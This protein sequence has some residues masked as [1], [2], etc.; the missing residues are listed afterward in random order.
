MQFPL[1]LV[2]DFEKTA[3]KRIRYDAEVD[4]TYFMKQI[5]FVQS[6]RFTAV[7]KNL[8]FPVVQIRRRRQNEITVGI[9]EAVS[10]K[11]VILACLTQCLRRRLAKTAFVALGESTQMGKATVQCNGRD[12]VVL[13]WREQSPA[14]SL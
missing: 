13:Q 1:N 11:Q 12:R 9:S 4:A 8:Q 3:S 7:L 6:V 14:R 10:S 5:A 2:R